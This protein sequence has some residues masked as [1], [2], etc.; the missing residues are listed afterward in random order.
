MVLNF[1]LMKV[2]FYLSNPYCSSPY[3][4]W[5]KLV[6]ELKGHDLVRTSNQL[7]PYEN[8]RYTG[9]APH[10]LQCPFNLLPIRNFI[11]LVNRRVRPKPTDESLDGM[12]HA[13][14]CPAKDDHWPVSNHP[15][16]YIHCYAAEKEFLGKCL[17]CLDLMRN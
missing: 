17:N 13:T 11:E 10:L 3:E 4:Q 6:P 8:S 1:E 16:N 12:A 5:D 15:C 2:Y 14:S 7:L 9:I